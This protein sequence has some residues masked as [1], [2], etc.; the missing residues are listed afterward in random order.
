MKRK[1]TKSVTSREPD[2]VA[3]QKNVAPAPVQRPLQKKLPKSQEE[4]VI[5]SRAELASQEQLMEIQRANRIILTVKCN[6]IRSAQITEKQ[7]LD[8]EMRQEDDR[9]YKLM[10]EDRKKGEMRAAQ[11]NEEKEKLNKEHIEVIKNQLDS[12]ANERQRQADRIKEEAD[13]L[14]LMEARL[15]VSNELVVKEKAQRREKLKR[16]LQHAYEVNQRIKTLNFEKERLSEIKIQEYMRQKKLHS[17]ALEAEKRL[18][19]DQRERKML[20]MCQEQMQVK[21]SQ[22]D[23]YEMWFQREAERKEQEF[24]RKELEAAV[25]RKE[26]EANIVK[27]RKMQQMEKVCKGSSE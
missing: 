23:K 25:K 2:I 14:A 16:D 27:E 8:R 11:E 13:H 6:L 3:N 15:Q 7:E 22:N 5:L 17:E 12:R 21:S 19:N 4:S 9:Y 10:E 26:L 20:R 1:S 18:Q 24:R